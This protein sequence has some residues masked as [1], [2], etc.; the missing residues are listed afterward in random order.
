MCT[1]FFL[2][3]FPLG[4]FNIWCNELLL[5]CQLFKHHC[6]QSTQDVSLVFFM[7]S[8]AWRCCAPVLLLLWAGLIVLSSADA[9]TNVS[10]DKFKLTTPSRLTVFLLCWRFP[11]T[12]WTGR[13]HAAGS[14]PPAGQEKSPV[15]A[16]LVIAVLHCVTEGWHPQQTGWI[17]WWK[18]KFPVYICS[19]LVQ[20]FEFKC[21]GTS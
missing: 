18:N 15:G 9:S 1:F 3:V 13:R 2:L 10:F 7:S 4:V 11:S 5:F 8:E 21:R 6:F 14:G 19:F 16:T 12:C 20:M 17:I